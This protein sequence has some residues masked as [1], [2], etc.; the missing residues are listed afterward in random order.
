[1]LSFSPSRIYLYQSSCDMRQSFNGLF[2][3]V[4]QHFP[5]VDLPGSLFVF[6]NSRQN[7]LKALYWDEDGFVL[8]SK[9]LRQGCFRRLNNS[10]K[11]ISRR[12]LS[13]MLEGISPRRLN[14]RFSLK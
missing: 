9:K 4:V 6:L 14:K 5:G 13:M 11:Q 7:Y 1:M 10:E 3:L 8:W 12:E 2:S